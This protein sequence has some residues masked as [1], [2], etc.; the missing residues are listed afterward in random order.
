[1]DAAMRRSDIRCLTIRPSWVQW[2]GNYDAQP[3]PRRCAIPRARRAPGL[4]AYIDVYDLADALRL[5]AESDLDTHEVFYI[6]SPDNSANRPL[7]DLIRH[8]HG[9]AI[10]IREPLPRPDASGLSIAK[11]E[12]LLGYAPTRSW[13]DYLTEDGTLLDAAR[14]R[15]ERGD[16]GVQ[17]GRAVG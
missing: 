16:T 6:A 3:R 11:A 2:E 8:H 12:R 5:A 14:E 4:W 10:E 15:L 17:R 1:M 13:R 7:A 9:D